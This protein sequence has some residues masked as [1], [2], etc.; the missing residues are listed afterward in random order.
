[1]RISRLRIEGF[2]GIRTADIHLGQSAVLV[3]P[4]NAGKTTVVEALALILGRE[5]MVRSLTEHDFFGSTPEPADR[6]KIVATIIDFPRPT[7]DQLP[8]WFS[9]KR[10]IPKW[11]DPVGGV[12]RAEAQPAPFK[13]A[14]N[15]AFQARFDLG[16]LEV[17][18]CRYFYDDDT[19]DD[20]FVDDAVTPVNIGLIRDVGFFLIPANRSWDRMISFGSELFRRVVSSNAGLPAESV[21][22]ERDRLRRPDNPLEND[23]RLKPVID[24]VNAEVEALFGP[25]H[26]VQLRL[27]GTDSAGVLDAVVPHFGPAG[28]LPIPSKR[29]GSGIVSLQSL[30]LL[31]H[32]GKQR[33]DFGKGFCLAV[34]E[35][36]LHLPPTIQ[37]RVLRRLKAL[38]SQVIVTTHSPLIAGFSEPTEVLVVSNDAGNL[39]A[40]P[41]LST[42]LTLATP[43]A[44]RN[45]FQLKR[46]ETV[47]ALMAEAVLVPEGHI[48][49]EWFSLLARI[50]ELQPAADAPGAVFSANI[51]IVPT[52]DSAVEETYRRIER[53]HSRATCIVDGDEQGSGYAAALERIG[54]RVLRWPD[55][56]SIEDIVAWVIQPAELQVLGALHDQL[57]NAPGTLA[58]L[59]DRLKR[60][61][62]PDHLKG[63]RVAYEI[64]AACIGDQEP[65]V[66]RAA[67]LLDAVALAA[68]GKETPRF[69]APAAGTVA[70]FEP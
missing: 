27:T 41:V 38:S 68:M 70:V 42:A 50:V 65:A 10:G 52:Y 43:N 11:Y 28:A 6:I 33:V 64:I 5:G 18:T 15:I 2:R 53:A 20:V 56:W 36:E 45:L 7:P 63:D 39:K 1:M 51:G 22:A 44:I 25:G 48:D 8:E 3:G 54:A 34:E 47:A 69:P 32:F 21:I 49:F 66:A 16:N 61:R 29:Q 55:G 57:P 14:C 24:E 31:L 17:E 40:T 19:H 30:F 12:E 35:P 13:L 23:A 59:T 9:K 62:G 46:V 60:G 67:Q 37:R 58:Q 26:A 4:S